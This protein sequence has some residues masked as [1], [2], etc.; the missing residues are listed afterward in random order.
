MKYLLTGP[1]IVARI[2]KRH[3]VDIKSPINWLNCP[4]KATTDYEAAA[5]VTQRRLAE[6]GMET[7]L[8][9]I[10]SQRHPGPRWFICRDY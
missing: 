5:K 7:H 4:E 3:V 10:P 2:R 8:E 9:E 1:D 6:L